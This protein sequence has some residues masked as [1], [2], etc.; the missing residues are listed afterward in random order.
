MAGIDDTMQLRVGGQMAA[1]PAVPSPVAPAAPTVSSSAAGS[2]ALATLR[3]GL[4]KYAWLVL[5][6]VFLVAVLAPV[7]AVLRPAQ[8]DAET[9][10][11]AKQQGNSSPNILPR[12]GATLFEQGEVARAVAARFGDGGNFDTIVPNRVSLT[13]VQDSIVFRVVGHA[14]SPTTAADIANVAADTFVGVLNAPGPE[15]GV[16]EIQGRATPPA[17]P[18]SPLASLKVLVPVSVGAGLV[19]GLALV[20]ALLI[21]RRPVLEPADAERATG[22]PTLGTVTVPRAAATE[23]PE[24]DEMS[25][26]VQVCRRLLALQSPTIFLAHVGPAGPGRRQLVVAMCAVLGWVRTVRFVAAPE[27]RA[28]VGTLVDGDQRPQPLPRPRG[29]PGLTLVDGDGM[30]DV[31]ESFDAGSTVLVVP[32]GTSLRDV[33][34]AAA[35]HLAG[36]HSAG[37]VLLRPGRRRGPRVSPTPVDP[38]PPTGR[39]AALGIR[40]PARHR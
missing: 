26:L 39:L 8:Y 34:S 14:A 7:I 13:A 15:V 40:T 27:L 11:I 17:A 2:D 3:W 21:V 32:T 1:R 24:A 9:L 16:F 33:R 5:G 23:F 37:I 12:Y 29:G 31:V 10:V 20:T 19:L 6:C 22:L 18:T 35:E 28:A 30:L 36:A 25:G 38:D 4:R